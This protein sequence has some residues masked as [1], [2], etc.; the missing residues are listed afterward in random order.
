M[1]R[2]EQ[3]WKGP[4]N[5]PW[6]I[7]V[8][9]D[10]ATTAH[11]A[12]LGYE[13][14]A[15]AMAS[16][17]NLLAYEA[18]PMF[19]VTR[20]TTP[21]LVYQYIGF[22]N[23]AYNK[24]WRKAFSYAFNYSYVIEELR[25]GNA[26][27]AVSAISPGFGAAHNASLVPG[28][29]EGINA[30]PDEGDIS[31]ARSVMQSMGYGI[32]YATEAD[33]TDHANSLNGKTPFLTA[34]YQFNSGN[35]FRTDLGVAVENWLEL[36]GVAVVQEP[37][38]WEAFLNY[39]FDDYDSLGIFAIGWAPDYLDPYNMLDPLFNPVSGSNSGQVNDTY[40]NTL[41]VNALGETDVLARNE[42]YKE[43]QWYMATNVFAHAP[44]YHSKVTSVGLANIYNVPYN[45]MGALRIYPMY[46]G[47]F[48][49]F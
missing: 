9:Y 13:L 40:L 43:I 18:D 30:V 46:R 31:I 34:T 29:L 45:A 8:I 42:I 39:L 25:L 33:W 16:D 15:N 26:Y 22:N 6:V 3:Y 12:M 5:F 44:L 10:D 48:P 17:Q 28:P 11:N 24:T 35:T 4:A 27:R 49:P 38:T 20:L 32:G 14:D 7:Y 1:K 2:W 37:L 23:E 41:M 21:S 36:I 47:L 19:R